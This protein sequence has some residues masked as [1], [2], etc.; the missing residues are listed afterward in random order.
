MT[1]AT[2]LPRVK[3]RR[4]NE[5]VE[6]P[7]LA[8]DE[9]DQGIPRKPAGD[10]HRAKGLFLHA[11]MHIARI[12]LHNIKVL[13][14]DVYHVV[15][16]SCENAEN[17][18]YA[19]AEELRRTLLQDQYLPMRRG[20]LELILSTGHFQVPRRLLSVRCHSRIAILSSKH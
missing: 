6:N 19:A 16:K 2:P 3:E 1:R 17:K 4:R 15:G 11:R 20:W 14:R 9:D 13:Q 8:L 5:T 10:A 12:A 18:A 7:E